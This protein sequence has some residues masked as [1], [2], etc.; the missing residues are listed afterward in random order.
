MVDAMK[1]GL[2][3]SGGGARGIVHL[4]VIKALEEAGIKPSIISGT[5]AGAIGGALYCSG[6]SPDEALAIIKKTKLFWSV[7]PALAWTGIL[8]M[9][10][11]GEILLKHLPQ[12][13][14]ESLE[15][16][17][18]VAATDFE[19]GKTVYFKKG[20]LI[21]PVLASSCVPVVFNPYKFKKRTFVDGGI[22]DNLPVK[23]LKKHCDFI[24]GSHCNPLLTT[25]LPA[26][27]RGVFERMM[28]MAIN[29]GIKKNKRRCD[30]VIEPP[31]LAV[32]SATDLGKAEEIFEIGYW[33]TKEKVLPKL[34]L[35]V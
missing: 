21:G 7:R 17:L 19:K 16:P 25:E 33:Y 28:L 1:I 3:L 2:A 14:F 9:D 13:S 20:E 11:I 6:H 26:N 10:A 5:S 24:I 34:K 18:V 4:G 32:Y 30:L 15:I 27:A 29:N 35:N 8:K 23:P 22:L 12:N 31:E